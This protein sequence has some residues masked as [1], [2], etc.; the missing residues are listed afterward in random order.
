M[1]ETLS[2]V[3]NVLFLNIMVINDLKNVPVKVPYFLKNVVSYFF[4]SH[5]PYISSRYIAIILRTQKI[6]TL[7]I[8]LFI[9]LAYSPDFNFLKNFCF[10]LQNAFLRSYFLFHGME[11]LETKE[12]HPPQQRT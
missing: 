8:Y 10:G 6:N 2:V 4:L 5:V 11:T 1:I 7:G 12:R 3:I 9:Q